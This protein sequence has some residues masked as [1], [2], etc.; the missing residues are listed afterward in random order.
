MHLHTHRNMTDLS[1]VCSAGLAQ[2]DR[3]NQNGA[4]TALLHVMLGPALGLG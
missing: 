4:P 3:T 2:A 1:A